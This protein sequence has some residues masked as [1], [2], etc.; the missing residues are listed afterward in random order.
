MSESETLA[1]VASL[2]RACR[3][4]TLATCDEAGEPHAASVQYAFVDAASERV[5]PP[6]YL[7]WVSSPRAAHSVHLDRD[8]AAAVVV[9]HPDDTDPSTL[10]GVQMRGRAYPMEVGRVLEDVEA[11]YRE[12]YPFVG[13]EPFVA[14]MPTLRHYR[15]VPA[16]LRLVD[17]GRG[18]GF[19]SEVALIAES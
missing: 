11:A 6:W 4:A 19:R 5:T 7:A 16:W 8:S 12:R 13:R 10:R 9:P 18:F 3:T 2:L 14:M 1:E 15:F 17:N